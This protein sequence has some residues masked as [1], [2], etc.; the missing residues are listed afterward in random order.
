[1][2]MVEGLD[3]SRTAIS[4]LELTLHHQYTNCVYSAVGTRVY[5][6]YP[7]YLLLQYHVGSTYQV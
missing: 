4:F 3:H 6:R 5:S 1:M 2:I 7:S